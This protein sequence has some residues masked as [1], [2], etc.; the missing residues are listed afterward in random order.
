VWKAK[1]IPHR[2][3]RRRRRDRVRNDMLYE[4]VEPEL[5]SLDSR[6]DRF[7]AL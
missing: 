5:V 2:R 3:F 1:Q 7:F 4:V 6:D